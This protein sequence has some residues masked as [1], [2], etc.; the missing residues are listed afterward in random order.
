MMP[1]KL[2]RLKMPNDNLPNISIGDF[3]MDILK[4]M[5][6]D[7]NALK[8]TVKEHVLQENNVPDLKGVEVTKDF[9]S[10]ILEGKKPQLAAKKVVKPIK[11]DKTA[12]LEELIGQLAILL[13]EAKILIEEVTAG[14]TTTGNIGVN[15]AGPAKKAKKQKTDPYLLAAKRLKDKY[16]I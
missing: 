2:K 15:L 4:D 16:N 12:K 13:K 14:T 3:A 9:V 11:E 5:S 7:P 8:P 10:L 1:K 6:A